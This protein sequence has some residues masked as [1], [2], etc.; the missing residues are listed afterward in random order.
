MQF[1]SFRAT[2]IVSVSAAAF[3]S[4]FS[5]RG[6]APL[7]F[8]VPAISSL[9]VGPRASSHRYREENPT[10]GASRAVNSLA[11]RRGAARRGSSRR[12]KRRVEALQR[13]ALI[14]ERIPVICGRPESPVGFEAVRG[15]VISRTKLIRVI[16]FTVLDANGLQRSLSSSTEIASRLIR[17]RTGRK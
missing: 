15:P 17:P 8:F 1:A 12:V 3:R 9:E 2:R 14:T 16:P 13:G 7:L 6:P 5:P 4:P 11:A 10:P